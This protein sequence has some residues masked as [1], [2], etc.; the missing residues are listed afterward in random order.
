MTSKFIIILCLYFILP[1]SN[2]FS[3]RYTVE[4]SD[5]VL[6]RSKIYKINGEDTLYTKPCNTFEFRNKEIINY[7]DANCKKQGMWYMYDNTANL[8]AKGIYK[9]SLK[10]G[11]WIYF[12][13]EYMTDTALKILYENG[14]EI[15]KIFYKDDEKQEVIIKSLSQRVF[16]QTWGLLLAILL[17]L[18][19]VRGAI[20]NTI[21]NELEKT[22]QS[23]IL[24]NPF[25]TKSLFRLYKAMFT[26]YWDKRVIKNNPSLKQK[27]RTS[28]IL[29]LV[30]IG[31]FV[32]IVLFTVITDSG[33]D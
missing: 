8:Y 19:Y 23:L 29:G 5:T 22:S 12:D 11:E 16:E 26:F 6:A 1:Q 9:E 7:Q 27:I 4:N 3:Q 32:S 24:V 33:I 14:D 17:I 15:K 25:K 18:F 30:L 21:Y 31:L 13:N 10:D 20:N 2:V 28:N